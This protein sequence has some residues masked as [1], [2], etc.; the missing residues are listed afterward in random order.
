M[1]RKGALPEL[2]APAGSIE[3]LY[4]AV[5]A[6]ADAVYVGGKSFGARAYAENFDTA[7]LARAAEYCHIKGVKLYVTVNTLVYDRELDALSDYV[8]ELWRIG[9]DA[10]ICADLGVAREIRRRVPNMELHAS[11]Q[12][13]VH[14]TLGADKAYLLG[15][16][17]VV[18]ARELSLDDIKSAVDN[19]KAEIEIFLHGALCVCHSGQCLFSSLVGGRSGNRGECAQPCRLPYNNGKYPL[20]LCDLSLAR[21]IKELCDLGVSS[22]KIEG[23][24]KS[25]DY[26]YNVTSIYRRLL[27]E[28]RDARGEEIDLL[29]AT[30]SRGGFTDGYFTDKKFSK[31]TGVRSEEDK[32]KTKTLS[33]GEFGIE[34]VPCE[35]ELTVKRG[36]RTSLRLSVKGADRSVCVMGDVPS[37]ANTSPL[38]EES[39][40]ARM[41][42]LGG[43]ALSLDPREVRVTL[44]GGL[45]LPPSSLNA[46]RRAAVDALISSEREEAPRNYSFEKYRK[47]SKKLHT[48]LFLNPKAYEEY[49][50]GEER[51]FF[52]IAFLP[53]ESFPDLRCGGDRLGVYIPP[54]I[55]DSELDSVRALLLTARE[56]GAE[57]ALLGNIG[58]IDLARDMG[59][60][61]IGDFRLNISNSESARAI[62]ELG[63]DDFLL[64]PE[65]SLPMARDIGG[66]EIVYGRIPLML[67]ER[68]F[69]KENFGCD[70]CNKAALTD[71]TGARFPLM[72]EFGHRNLVLN[73]ALTYMGDRRG[74]LDEAKIYHRHFIFSCESA[75]EISAAVSA[76]KKGATL[77]TSAVRRIGIRRK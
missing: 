73:S 75:R 70:K 5:C 38:T 15:C 41:C 18:L 25:P 3:A 30:F 12:M 42:K 21:H 63:I 22:L 55:F 48:G 65:L 7:A 49:I 36:E 33:H 53:L 44:D 46:L 62:S 11:T 39:V 13:S 28:M 34:P 59:F 60:K 77:G 14:N 47:K 6:G 40:R 66:G 51:P 68:C 71:R 50:K 2:L 56:H 43:T 45:N 17:R 16:E 23:R 10:I 52:D 76:Y 54:V 24:M 31:M 69:I 20:S 35:A 27:D 29:K 1:K 58:Q 9:V 19:S 4:A 37:E 57:Y 8:G 64:S 74:E 61:L 32:E 72:R 67:T 26:V